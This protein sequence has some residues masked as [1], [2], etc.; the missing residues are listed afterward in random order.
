MHLKIHSIYDESRTV[1]CVLVKCLAPRVQR[2]ER[3]SLII[4]LMMMGRDIFSTNKC[5][6]R[7]LF[8]LVGP[9]SCLL[10]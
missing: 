5:I 9:N 10:C 2:K 3:N 8:Y 4:Y 7:R 6:F 1:L